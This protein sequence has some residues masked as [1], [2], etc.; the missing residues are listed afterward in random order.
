ME[1]L[2]PPLVWAQTQPAAAN[3]NAIA[4][5]ALRRWCSSLTLSPPQPVPSLHGLWGFLAGLGVLLLVALCLQGPILVLKQLFDLPGH[6]RLVETAAKRVWRAGRMVSIAIGFTVL[7]WTAAQ[8]F[9]FLRDAGQRADLSLLTKS[10]RPGELAVEQGVLA[11]LTPLRD[12]AGLS[13]N[14]PLLL[15]AAIMLLRVSLDLPVLAALSNTD[16]GASP[17]R[18]S[19]GGST[20]VCGA[21]LLYALY[22][23]VGWEAGTNELPIGGCLVVEAIFIPLAMLIADGFLM[24]WLLTE[25]RDAGFDDRGEDRLDL[26]RSMAVLPAA[27]LACFLALPARYVATFVWLSS[28][29]LPTSVYAGSLGRV[30]RWQL[31]WGLTDLQAVALVGVGLAGAVAW[32]RGTFRGS[33]AGYRRLLVAN[34]GHLIAVLLMAGVA[35]GLPAAAVYAIL[36]LLP[37]QSW[38]LGA[39]DSYSHYVTLPVG[40]WTLSALIE[41]AERSLPFASMRPSSVHHAASRT[42]YEAEPF[43]HHNDTTRPGSVVNGGRNPVET[44]LDDRHLRQ[45]VDKPAGSR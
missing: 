23:A 2:T 9:V 29:Y 5:L 18:R 40:L 35:A 38:V 1:L 39:A 17:T 21:A 44:G 42:D 19:T 45:P 10:R 37:A 20:L 12:V 32:S 41:L 36:L 25:L 34:A 15:F 7:S 28:W 8:A 26:R 6:L 4:L 11:G 14:L 31:G 24:A 22:R 3:P 27:A 30:I 33:I 13:D 16:I 43:G